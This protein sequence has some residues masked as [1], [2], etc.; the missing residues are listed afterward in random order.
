MLDHALNY[1]RRTGRKPH[2]SGSGTAQCGH[3]LKHGRRRYGQ[4]RSPSFDD[5][6]LQRRID[7]GSTADVRYFM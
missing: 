7:C 2:G 3:R 1:A 4:E 6:Q 5:A